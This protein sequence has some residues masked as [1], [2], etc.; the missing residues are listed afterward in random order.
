MTGT[1][2][3]CIH[4]QKDKKQDHQLHRKKYTKLKLFVARST[5][6]NQTDASMKKLIGFLKSTLQ[7]I[8]TEW[9]Q[10][11]PNGIANMSC[12]T[13]TRSVASKRKMNPWRF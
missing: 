13:Y 5:G 6:H 4:R 1:L 3:V 11:D 2:K 9:Q 8:V 12:Q 7:M 10:A